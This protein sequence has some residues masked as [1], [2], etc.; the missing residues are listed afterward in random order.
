MQRLR[1]WAIRHHAPSEEIL[2][3]LLLT[4]VSFAL[5]Y[6]LDDWLPVG[7]P[8]LTFFPAVTIASFI[9][10]SRAGVLT[11][12]FCGI[13]AYVFFIAPTGVAWGGALAMTFYAVVTGTDLTL[14]QLMRMALKRLDASRKRSEYLAEQNRLMFHE[15]QHRVSN[16]LQVVGSI[17][18]MQE[19]ALKDPT[20]KS[21]L[22]AASARLRVISGI[23]RQLHNPD[24]QSAD[25]TALLTALLP[26]VAQGSGLEARGEVVVQGA[27][28]V[29]D[30]DRIT[31]VGLVVVE[32]VSNA[33]E[34]A[35]EGVK[36]TVTVMVSAEEA[37][38]EVV[39]DGAG[40]PEGFDAAAA[41]SL[42]LRLAMQFAAQL[43]GRLEFD[44]APAGGTRAAL[45]FPLTEG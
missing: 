5:R 19:R 29:L 40:L 25:I 4:S 21:A 6:L 2:T 43:A 13:L 31:P 34:H 32:L 18:K 15:L 44:Q 39:D 33:L 14:L 20:A 42:G 38:L 12:V 1:R 11:A 26:E 3:V 24:R 7:F 41:P 10:S 22:A 8:F 36:I 16:S 27:P 23:Q 9:S 30:P 45:H 37:V 35:G 28:L 17:L